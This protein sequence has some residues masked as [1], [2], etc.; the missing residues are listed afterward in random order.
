MQAIKTKYFGPTNSNPGRI[1]ATAESGS[2]T[3]QYPH[4]APGIEAA[5]TEAARALMVKMGWTGTLIAGGVKDG[6]VFVFQPAHVERTLNAL[7]NLVQWAIGNRGAKE[8]NP[9]SSSKPEMTEALHALYFATNGCDA[10]ANE[11]MDA[12][13]PWRKTN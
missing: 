11:Y 2:I 4:G 13:E 1:K 12:A 5:H 3:I 8:G 6:Y 7:G 9:Y 10:F